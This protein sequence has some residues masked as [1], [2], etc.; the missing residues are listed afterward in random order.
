[1]QAEPLSVIKLDASTREAG[2]NSGYMLINHLYIGV[3][4]YILTT[5]KPKSECTPLN[6]AR[7]LIKGRLI[8]GGGCF[9]LLHYFN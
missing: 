1:M 8:T 5:C 4:I 6:L 7:A 2:H 3:K 9:L